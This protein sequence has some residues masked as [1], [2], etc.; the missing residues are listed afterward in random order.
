MRGF[1]EWFFLFL[2]KRIYVR[3]TIRVASAFTDAFLMVPVVPE[4]PLW[5]PNK[6]RRRSSL[7]RAIRCGMQEGSD[8]VLYEAMVGL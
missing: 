4:A 8:R 6:F 3:R 7:E 5:G 2:I 1:R